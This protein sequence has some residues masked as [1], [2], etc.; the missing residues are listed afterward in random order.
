[1]DLLY[2]KPIP[3]Q[4]TWPLRKRVMW[5]DRPLDFVKIP[6]DKDGLHYGLFLNEKLISIVS[7][8]QDEENMQFR[9]FA[10]ETAFQGRGYGSKLLSF[11]FEK[12]AESGIKK[13]WCNARK[14]KSGFYKGFGMTETQ[15]T[16]SKGG[17]SYVIMEKFLEN[18]REGK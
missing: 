18:G 12:A 16:F 11:V 5:P 15:T 1:M 13:I 6:S 8:F 7:L 14:D 2:I 10:T 4:D 17:I 3:F 9:K